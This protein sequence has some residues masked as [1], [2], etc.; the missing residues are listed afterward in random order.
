MPENGCRKSVGAP[1][2][3]R[4]ID[5]GKR[6]ITRRQ[7]EHRRFKTE[8]RKASTY[9]P[10][11]TD[12]AIENR[13]T[14]RLYSSNPP[15]LPRAGSKKGRPAR[16]P[17]AFS[18]EEKAKPE[19]NKGQRE[20]AGTINRVIQVGNC[21]PVHVSAQQACDQRD[22]EQPYVQ[23]GLGAPNRIT[24]RFERNAMSR[25]DSDHD[26]D[27]KARCCINQGQLR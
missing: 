9:N 6:Q 24:A 18:S 10:P 22:A 19:K 12:T 15:A 5:R 16:D 25:T 20:T 8:E 7:V 26:A 11:R 17:E 14:S 23:A 3:R 27:H 13:S 4:N 2:F 21:P 1:I